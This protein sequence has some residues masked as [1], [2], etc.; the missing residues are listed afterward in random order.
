MKRVEGMPGVGTSV[1]ALARARVPAQGIPEL[2]TY[3]QIAQVNNGAGSEGFKGSEMLSIVKGCRWVLYLP[4]KGLVAFPVGPVQY[5][6]LIRLTDRLD[7][8]LRAYLLG[9]YAKRT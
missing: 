7:A 1:R 8:P 5:L 6:W 4:L 3:K 9:A 2:D